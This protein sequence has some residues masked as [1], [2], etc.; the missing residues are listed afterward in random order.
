MVCGC[1]AAQLGKVVACTRHCVMVGYVAEDMVQVADAEC[2][3]GAGYAG[4]D[5]ASFGPGMA[6]ANG[7]L[8]AAVVVTHAEGNL[9]TS[10]R[11][12]V[13]FRDASDGAVGSAAGVPRLAVD[14]YLEIPHA[15]QAIPLAAAFQAAEAEWAYERRTAARPVV[16][17]GDLAW[18]PTLSE[19]CPSYTETGV[20]A[21]ALD[22]MGAVQWAASV[23]A[24]KKQK[25]WV[26]CRIEATA[27]PFP[28]AAEATCWRILCDG[29]VSCLEALGH[30]S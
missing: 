4:L 1:P 13:E 22:Y 29:R 17:P 18:S 5:S 26:V 20:L 25:L 28:K 19:H 7:T 9:S 2:A 21:V 24:K 16:E 3:A 23:A 30:G 27:A 11:S 14:G 12:W 6:V 15:A 10:N 8:H